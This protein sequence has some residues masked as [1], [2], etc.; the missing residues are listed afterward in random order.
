MIMGEHQMGV[1]DE[2][3]LLDTA[4]ASILQVRHG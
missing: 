3:L 4:A 2:A 1:Q